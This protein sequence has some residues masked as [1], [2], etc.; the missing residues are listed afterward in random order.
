MTPNWDDPAVTAGANPTLESDRYSLALVFLRVVG[1]ANFPIQARQ[2]Q[3]GPITVD[4]AVPSNRF[5]EA[6]LGPGAPLWDLCERGLSVSEPH[7][8]PPAGAWVASLEAVLDTLGA[9]TL[10]R[11]V[12]ANQGGGQPSPVLPLEPRSG[13]PGRHNPAGPGL[14]AGR[15]QMDARAAAT[16]CPVATIGGAGPA[17]SRLDRCARWSTGPGP[18][19]TPT[20]P[21]GP[22]A[23]RRAG[24]RHD[25]PVPRPARGWAPRPG[26]TC[27]KRSPGGSPSIGAT[28]HALWTSGQR[29]EGARHLALCAAVDFVTAL[30]GLFVVAMIVA[31]VLGI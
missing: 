25:R 13:P 31:P 26:R 21:A 14:A 30:V 4:F 3:G 12:W 5:G 11:S 9:S 16:G 2:R 17:A 8:R 27:G 24:C 7:L 18:W 20:A 6:L 19:Q 29:R 10:M 23:T 15:P 1:A 22:G 28:M